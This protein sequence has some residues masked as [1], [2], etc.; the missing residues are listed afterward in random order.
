MKHTYGAKLRVAGVTEEDQNFLMG[1]KGRMRMATY[2]SVPELKKMLEYSTRV[3][4]RNN[5]LIFLKKVFNFYF[6]ISI[7]PDMEQR[8]DS[9]TDS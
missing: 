6:K 7:P 8:E 3:C 1:H 4:E 9:I 2:Y 5:N